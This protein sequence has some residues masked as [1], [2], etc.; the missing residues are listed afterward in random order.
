MKRF[1]LI[2]LFF[3]TLTLSAFAFQNLEYPNLE[4]TVLD[5]KTVSVK[6]IDNTSAEPIIIPDTVNDGVHDYAVTTI[7]EKGFF[8]FTNV[9]AFTLPEG[10]TTIQ[11]KAFCYCTSLQEVVIIPSTVTTI[12]DLAFA[13]WIRY[14]DFET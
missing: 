13:S 10:L 2:T 11:A 5:A 14:V 6:G 4:F 12:G 1:S 3:L 7:A 8:K 9:T